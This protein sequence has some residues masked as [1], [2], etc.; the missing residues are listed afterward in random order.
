[1]PAVPSNLK[2]WQILA[3]GKA[4]GRHPRKSS[5]DNCDPG[6]VAESQNLPTASFLAPC[7]GAASFFRNYRWSPLPS[8][9]RL[10]SGIP[11]GWYVI[12]VSVARANGARRLRRFGVAK[13]Q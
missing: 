5:G 10:I 9:H 6:G 3:G 1:M 4:K 11:L 12:T 13:E 2:G 8:D 7:Q